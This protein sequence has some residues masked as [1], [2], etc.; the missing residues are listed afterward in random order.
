M[1]KFSAS[2]NLLEDKDKTFELIVAWA[3]TFGRA[4]VII[5]EIV[6]LAAFLYRFSLDN[7]LQTS[8][9]KI[10]EEQAIVNYQK[11]S[12][13][14]YRDLQDRLALISSVSKQSAN[15]LK[16]FNDIIALTPSGFTFNL[17]D[18][19]ASRV[20]VDADATSVVAISDFIDKL[21]SYPLVDTVSLDKIEN[22]TSTG[23]ISVGI[24]ANFKNQG[25]LNAPT[26]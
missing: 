1:A 16:V 18:I 25:G 12:E 13:A 23:I 6:A 14:K 15:N 4:L 7:Q 26:N 20:Q 19:S 17:F 5:V 2:I 21:K 10:K 9:T 22:D 3:L 11:D 24:T 8:R